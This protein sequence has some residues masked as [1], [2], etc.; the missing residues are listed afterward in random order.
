MIAEIFSIG[1]E[2]LLGDI[3]DTNSKFIAKK[4]SDSG[5]NV[6]KMQTIGDNFARLVDAFKSLDGNVDYVITSG[7]LGPTGDDLTKEALI[8]AL[9]LDYEVELHQE[10]YSKLLDYFNNNEEK[11]KANIKQA[12]FPNSAIVLNNELGT[13]PGALVESS[14]GTKYIIMPGPPKEMENMFN[15]EVIKYLPKDSYMKSV[16]VKIG[17]L[18][19][20]QM[21]SKIDLDRDKPT[22]SPYITNEGPVLRIT[23]KDESLDEVERQI[24]LGL[25]LVKEEL[26]KFVI[27][28]E[29]IRKEEVLV[30]QLKERN[31]LVSTAESVTGGMIA[32]SIIDISG[33]SSVLKE[34]YIVYSNEIK[35]KILGV[36]RETINEYTVV[37]SQVLI[38]MLDGLYNI[39]NSN[40][41][42]A[43]TG[44]AHTGEVYLGILYNGDK[45]IKHLQISGDRN[46][47]RN[48]IKNYAI[49]MAIMVMRGVYED[50]IDI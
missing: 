7:G 11:T 48:K 14:K 37:S 6:Y 40:L 50:N 1:T 4:L 34:S 8:R 16:F 12:M 17:L 13:A 36:S 3:V 38:E 9:D 30:R 31:E 23:A 2:I 44:Y 46:K 26:G 10:S 32:S 5:I 42:I 35:E 24:N 47:V 39:T 25:D 33:A 18:G 21:A 27:T 45:Y 43:T 22:I 15:N 49:D 28:S 19:E 41:C 29:D 20:W